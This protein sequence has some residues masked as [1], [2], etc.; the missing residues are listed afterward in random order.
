MRKWEDIVR[1]KLEEPEGELPESVFAEFRAR[2]DAAAPAPK[3]FRPAWALVPALAAALAAVLLIHKPT[4]SERDSLVAQQE[5]ALVAEAA[6]TADSE[7]PVQAEAPADI[8]EEMP[9]AVLPVATANQA[10][11][12]PIVAQAKSVA[13]RAAMQESALPQQAAVTESSTEAKTAE[14]EEMPEKPDSAVPEAE[15]ATPAETASSSGKAEAPE[16]AAAAPQAVETV[17]TG[18]PAASPFVPANRNAR[19]VRKILFPTAG[20]LTG[21]GLLATAVP[22]LFGMREAME[23]SPS[24]D[25]TTQ[26]EPQKDEPT[27]NV[28]YFFPRRF[29][30]SARFPISEK[31]SVTTGLDYSRYKSSIAYSLSGEKM[32]TAH[33]LGIPL[34]L[35]WTFASTKR[36]DFYLGGGLEGDWCIKATFDGEQVQKDGFSASLMGAGGIQFKL[37]KNLGL[38][39]E[40]EFNWTFMP[41]N[42]VLNT[43][44]SAHPVMFS[45]TSGLRITFGK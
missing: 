14:A 41:E 30:L 35:D 11:T 26:Q 17:S 40:P 16:K 36:L 3:R 13:P 19:I 8:A 22:L 2:L 18:H 7:E 5:P 39:M 32:Q 44:R 4:V 10:Q 6:V 21:G 25:L 23:V 24:G 42:P 28:H 33:Y 38:Y 31:L 37:T 43:Y 45:V 29:G 15:A 1:D 20:V 34:R 9:T 27:G 12:A